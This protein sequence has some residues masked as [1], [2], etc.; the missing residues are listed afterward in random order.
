MD[1]AEQN[2]LP[3][4]A[5]DYID[6]V[7]KNMRYRRTVR[8]EVRQELTDHFT[9]ALAD[10]QTDAERNALAKD[11]IDGFGDVELLAILLRRAKKRCR[12]LWRTMVVR[13]FQAVGVLFLLLVIYIG[14]FLTGKPVITTNY[15]EVMNRQVRPAAD[16]AMNAWPYFK[17]AAELYQH[18]AIEPYLD[19]TET[20]FIPRPRALS[21][22]TARERDMLMQWL[23]DNQA[24]LHLIRAGISKPHYWQVYKT[25][26][27]DNSEMVSMYVPGMRS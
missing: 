23:T 20:R 26:K 6:A 1:K 24:S 10:C 25:D 15:L 8:Q 18:Q 19:D 3:A 13:T 27:D 11:L 14:W 12:P 16:D 21:A 2:K 7:M 4:V 5:S 17:Q 22:L 9:D